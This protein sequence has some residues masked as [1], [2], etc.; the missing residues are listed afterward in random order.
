MTIKNPIFIPWNFIEV[1]D[2]E[3]ILYRRVPVQ[4]INLR[5]IEYRKEGLLHRANIWGICKGR[6]VE[7]LE[8]LEDCFVA[9]DENIDFETLKKIRAPIEDMY[10]KPI[11]V[12]FF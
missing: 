11:K 12:T 2:G 5:I 8:V 7:E 3:E 10:P 9:Y 6:G 1:R 4:G